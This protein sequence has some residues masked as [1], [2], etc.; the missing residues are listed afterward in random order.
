VTLLNSTWRCHC[1]VE[2]D[3]PPSTYAVALRGLRQHQSEGT[4]VQGKSGSGDRIHSKR[5]TP[6]SE[7]TKFVDKEP[8][9]A[10]HGPP[11]PLSARA[12]DRREGL[13]WL[14]GNQLA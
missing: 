14:P 5:P 11:R 4:C 7:L 12:R 3:T 8:T 6:V 9:P 2:Q 10:L 13:P 1:G